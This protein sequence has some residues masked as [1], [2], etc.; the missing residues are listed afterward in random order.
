MTDQ[1][2]TLPEAA[3]LTHLSKRQLLDLNRKGVLPIIKVN[4]RVFRIAESDL[5]TLT[6]RVTANSERGV[7]PPNVAQDL[8][9]I[10]GQVWAERHA[11]RGV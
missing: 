6:Q 2:L 10:Y 3:A 4:A 9:A 5:E 1:L 7:L 8:A 11:G